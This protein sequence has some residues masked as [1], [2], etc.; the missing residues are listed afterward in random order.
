MLSTRPITNALLLTGPVCDPAL[1]RV[2]TVARS[3]LLDEVGAAM[4]AGDE[5]LSLACAL[6][7]QCYVNDYVFSITEE[8]E[9]KVSD[10]CELVS[11]RH[12]HAVHPISLATLAAYVPLSSLAQSDALSRETWIRPFASIV[13][14]QLLEPAEE[15]LAQ[16]DIPRLTRIDNAV[17]VTVKQQYEE[18]PYPKWDSESPAGAHRSPSRDISRRSLDFASIQKST[19]ICWLL[20]AERDGTPSR[21]LG[22]SAI[23]K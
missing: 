20:V 14:Q 8:E 19:P 10:L 23:Q 5:L 22:Y 2:L 18:S 1:E 4:P 7:Q 3:N 16:Q 6:A 21:Q 9:D 17:S 11:S 15:A 12:E 13:R